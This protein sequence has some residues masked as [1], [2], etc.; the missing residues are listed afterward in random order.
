MN[1]A[2]AGGDVFKIALA[3]IVVE[4]GRLIHVV[5]TDDV[6]TAVA[7]VVADADAHAGHL[8]AVVIERDPAQ[9]G[10][11]AKSCRRGC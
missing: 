10:L 1:Q 2:G 7:V 8:L 4:A 5:G 3:L 11:F 9:Q 6:Q